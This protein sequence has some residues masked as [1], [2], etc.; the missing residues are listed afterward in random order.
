[1][2]EIEKKIIL[3]IV[4]ILLSSMVFGCVIVLREFD[5]SESRDAIYKHDVFAN[6]GQ[7]ATYFDGRVYYVSQENDISG[8]YSMANDGSDEK[9][10][11]NIPLITRL[12]ITDDGYYF[13][14]TKELQK[15][16]VQIFGFYK[17]N[18]ED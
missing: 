4:I 12:T 18:K 14:G 5:Y 6:T 17:V 10:E 16:S 2:K 3:G 11:F 1:M 7:S 9:L 8:I 15:G 13:V